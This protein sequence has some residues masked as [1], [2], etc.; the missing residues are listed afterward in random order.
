MLEMPTCYHAGYE[1][2]RSLDSA[3]AESYVAHAMRG[4][5]RAD[6]V[7]R[8]LWE[9][10]RRDRVHSVIAGAID[11]HRN[12]P[13]GTPQTLRDLIEEMSVVPDWYDRELAMS[14]TR[15]FMRNSDM[16]L[17]G[18]VAGSIIE[19][20]STLISKSFRIRGRVLD[21]G[22]R[23]LRQNILHLLEQY[24]P[25][26]MEP[27]NDGWKLTMRIRLVH[28]QARF[29]ITESGEW[30]TETY[31]L[32]LSGA[33]LGLAAASFSGRLMQHVQHLGGDMTEEEI[34]GY[35]HVWRNT[36]RVM[37]VPEALTFH[38]NASAV[39]LFRVALACEP[40][41][42][43]DGIIMANSIINSAPIIVG[44]QGT[45]NCRSLSKFVYQ[46]SRE[47]I[48]NDAADKLRFPAGK[49]RKEIPFLRLRNF[50]ERIVAKALP[51][52]ADRLSKKRLGNL[53]DVTNLGENR[54]SYRLPSAVF[55]EESAKW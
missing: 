1:T 50:S 2:A 8:E 20:F 26:G 9:T 36:A 18:L 11:N 38:D 25:D 24:M 49:F 47:L 3:M 13:P 21:N 19:G 46:I 35:V 34:E 40:P 5:D 55:D 45:K 23:R 39:R 29:L 37:G 42:D 43:D 4:D 28:A 17:A 14:G 53:L 6:A 16:V 48:G 41:P 51:F 10:I 33:N 7:V 44:V 15:G 12:P 32:P 27:G 22:V 54:I 31:G 52:M 30:D